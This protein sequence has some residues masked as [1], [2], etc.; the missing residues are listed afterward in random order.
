M[1][2]EVGVHVMYRVERM[3]ADAQGVGFVWVVRGLARLS[4]QMAEVGSQCS[5][6]KDYGSNMARAGDL[7]S[8]PVVRQDRRQTGQWGARRGET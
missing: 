7:N 8:P 4:R 3:T 6:G 1:V 5:G 2:A